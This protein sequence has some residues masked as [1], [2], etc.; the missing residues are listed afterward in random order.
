MAPTPIEELTSAVR[1]LERD[2]TRLPPEALRSALMLEDIAPAVIEAARN[3]F[4]EGH[5]DEARRILVDPNRANEVW[6]LLF[7]IYL[8]YND[9]RLTAGEHLTGLTLARQDFAALDTSGVALPTFE[10]HL[11]A[12]EQGAP[13]LRPELDDE[14]VIAAFLADIQL[15]IRPQV[16][17]RP[18]KDPVAGA[19]LVPESRLL[20]A[21]GLLVRA[22]WGAGVLT[23]TPQR[24]LGVVFDDASYFAK[25]PIPIDVRPEFGAIPRST[26]QAGKLAPIIGSVLT[27]SADRKLFARHEV[28]RGGFMQNRLSNFQLG[29]DAPIALVGQVVRAVDPSSRREIRPRKG[30]VAEALSQWMS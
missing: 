29:G 4:A 21:Q 22:I 1:D 7:M 27:F 5:F 9:A 11:S 23:F 2:W 3:A 16:I 10:A 12:T 13:Y 20:L 18:Q 17:Q 6:D 28:P 14:Q 15:C 25:P 24:V 26:M 30:E 19:L 8:R